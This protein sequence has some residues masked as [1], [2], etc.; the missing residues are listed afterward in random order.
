M[1]AEVSSAPRGPREAN[2]AMQGAVRTTLP[3]VLFA[4]LASACSCD[5]EQARND[6]MIFI[7][8]VE[9][10]DVDDPLEDRR[11]VVESIRA[12]ALTDPSV[13]AARDTCVEAYGALIEA[14]DQHALARHILVGTFLPDGG[15]QEIPP[16][17]QAEIEAALDHSE[18]AIARSREAI[19][20]CTRAVGE[21]E[22]RFPRRH[23]QQPS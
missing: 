19:P 1:A 21:L 16:E 17:T 5:D 12:L 3:L 22:H 20:R 6:A 2:R 4:L 10:F 8:R 9:E 23:S 7:D 13:V 11:Q 14:E 15:E 18:D